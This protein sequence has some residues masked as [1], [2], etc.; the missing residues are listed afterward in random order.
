MRLARLDS[1]K[2]FHNHLINYPTPLNIN[3]AWGFGSLAG[4]YLV[5]Q[6]VT[7]LVLSCHYTADA[8]LAFISTEHIMRNV[9]YGWLFRYTHANG[10]SFFFIIAYLHIARS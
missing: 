5:I 2:V 4:F 6:I 8:S 3:Y 9:N 10:A 7:G 1:L